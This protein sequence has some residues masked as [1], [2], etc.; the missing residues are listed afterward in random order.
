MEVALPDSESFRFS[1]S[2]VSIDS[3]TSEIIRLRL[4]RPDGFHY[5]A[6]Q[7]ITLYNPAGIGRSYSLASLPVLDP[8]L[9]LHIRIVPN[10]QVSAWVHKGLAVGDAVS[11]SEAIGNCFYVPGN[12]QQSMLLVGTGSGLAP[13]YGIVRD[14]LHQA[15]Q[16]SIKLYHG[17]STKAGI[18]LQQEL[19]QLAQNHSN[20]QYIACV[21]RDPGAPMLQGRATALAMEQNPKLTGWRAYICGEP[22]MVKETSRAAFLAGV[23]LQEI[24]SDPFIHSKP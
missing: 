15:H 10:G 18:Y 13:L 3:L 4:Q 2:V 14:A 12:S 24:Y 7:F 6:G 19:G 8:F 16:G 1:T 11:I 20:F 22:A 9:E 23:S 5:H 17:S 21:S